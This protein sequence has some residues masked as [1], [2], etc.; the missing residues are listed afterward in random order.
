MCGRTGREEWLDELLELLDADHSR[1]VTF[2][3]FVFAMR[4]TM[5]AAAA[6]AGGTVRRST[7][8]PLASY[9][10]EAS[11]IPH[12]VCAILGSGFTIPVYY[13]R[14]NISASLKI[15]IWRRVIEQVASKSTVL[16]APQPVTP[17]PTSH[18]THQTIE[19]N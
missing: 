2:D 14:T 11:F 6:R 12:Y 8:P 9:L 19:N 18:I 5:R 4:Q 13:A 7:P 17:P 3:E 10:H 16:A 15:Q 1:S